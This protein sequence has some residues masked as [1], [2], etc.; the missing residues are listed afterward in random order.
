MDEF[1]II[2]IL[3]NLFFTAI[4]YL[5]FP[6]VFSRINHGKKTYSRKKII[7]I[8]IVNA[9]VVKIIISFLTYPDVGSFGPT[10]L[11]GWVGYEML[12]SKLLEPPQNV[13]DS[14]PQ[15]VSQQ[16]TQGTTA[17]VILD[18]KVKVK[19]KPVSKTVTDNNSPHIT[20]VPTTISPNIKQNSKLNIVLC[21][22]LVCTFC[23]SLYLYSENIELSQ[24]LKETQTTLENLKTSFSGL[25]QKYQDK[26]EEFDEIQEKLYNYET[27][28]VFVNERYKFYV[29]GSYHYI[30]CPKVRLSGAS[31]YASINNISSSGLFKICECELQYVYDFAR[32]K[33]IIKN[34][35]P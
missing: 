31:S 22:L 12:K 5:F 19:A 13:A 17:S 28:V 6:F 24:Q 14:V 32:S 18:E 23:T 4:I 7:L 27:A 34:K 29:D 35:L 8:A 15:S 21:I 25:N 3:L 1:N 11:W 2:E 10:Y 16:H 20:A 33:D 9:L 26:S 30:T